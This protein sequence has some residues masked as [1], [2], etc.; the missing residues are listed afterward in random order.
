MTRA[1]FFSLVVLPALSAIAAWA[2]GGSAD[3]VFA[4]IPLNDWLRGG[5]RSALRWSQ[6]IAPAR[7]STQQRLLL[8]MTIQLDGEEIADRPGQGRLLMLVQI[9]DPHGGVWQDHGAT[10]LRITCSKPY[11]TDHLL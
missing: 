11:D 5:E 3:P 1:R 2:Q 6:H 4:D 9:T 10:I 7:L 8:Q